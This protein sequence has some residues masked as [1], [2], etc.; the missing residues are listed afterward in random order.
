MLLPD[1]QD[2]LVELVR[3][4]NLTSEETLVL[5]NEVLQEPVTKVEEIPEE[6]FMQVHEH[7]LECAGQGGLAELAGDEFGFGEDE[8]EYGY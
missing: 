4:M 7:L 8:E 3:L 1:Q 6:E 2:I 5:V